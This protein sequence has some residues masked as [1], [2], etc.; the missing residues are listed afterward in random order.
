MVTDEAA[1]R[2]L[3]DAEAR[4]WFVPFLAQSSSISAAARTLGEKPNSVLYRVKRWLELGLLEVAREEL[5]KGRTVKHY[6]STSDAFFI[7]HSASSSE[8]L[9]ELLRD[10]N[11]PY[12]DTLYQSVVSAARALSSDWGVQLSR[13]GTTVKV[14]AAVAPGEVYDPLNR[15]SPAVLEQFTRLQLDFEDAKAF[16]LELLN[17]LKN[18]GR[19]QGAQRYV[20]YLALAPLEESK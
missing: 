5:R 4:R 13:V 19:K 7:P 11:A 1:A 20:S 12:L 3:L 6:R 9:V 17:L 14:S 15:E 18:Y 2:V 10:T 8:T 16:Q